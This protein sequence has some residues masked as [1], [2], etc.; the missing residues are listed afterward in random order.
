MNSDTI[1]RASALIAEGKAYTPGNVAAPRHIVG[2][3]TQAAVASPAHRAP[4]AL[5]PSCATNQP[6]KPDDRPPAAQDEHH[7]RWGS[8]PPSVVR[9][10][11]PSSPRRLC[12]RE[13]ADRPRLSGS[14][15]ALARAAPRQGPR[16]GRGGGEGRLLAPSPVPGIG[17]AAQSFK[18]ARRGSLDKASQ[19]EVAGLRAPIR[20]PGMAR[21]VRSEIDHGQA[22][23]TPR[24]R[25]K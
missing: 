6:R 21:G 7:R 23:A 3:R 22:M 20:D 12:R 5:G 13:R 15:A 11:R 10:R 18:R 19:I 14:R 4:P 17:E 16:G 9:S 25:R 2:Q 8:S 1:R 24:A